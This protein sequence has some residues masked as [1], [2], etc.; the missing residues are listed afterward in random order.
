VA[1]HLTVAA[2]AVVWPLLWQGPRLDLSDA[3]VVNLVANAPRAGAPKAAAQTQTPA[4]EPEA[5]EE[6]VLKAEAPEAKEAAPEKAVSLG[7][8]PEAKGAGR[9]SELARALEA[10]RSRVQ[11]EASVSAAIAQM[12]QRVATRG[13]AEEGVVASGQF[14]GGDVPLS[15]RL[16]YEEV[17]KRVRARWVLPSMRPQGL[18]AV[19][20]V[21]IGRD[22]TIERADIESGSGDERF[23]RSALNA[24]RA[25]SPLPPL[26]G[27]YLGRWHEI[28]IRFHQ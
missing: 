8:A 14:S 28:G 20:A 13:Q 17:W 24:V 9:E 10:I 16:Y 5:K 23:D 21:R 3:F 19:V 25:A 22:G 18:K 26:P 7:Q 1:V 4:A 2:L 27:D 11:R 6:K 12:R 15:F